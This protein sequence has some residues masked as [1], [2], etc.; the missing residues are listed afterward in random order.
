MIL[1]GFDLL[2]VENLV[3]LYHLRCR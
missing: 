3:S 2:N 1:Y